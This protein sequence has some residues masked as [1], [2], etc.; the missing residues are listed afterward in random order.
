MQLGLSKIFVTNKN[1]K[2]LGLL[3]KFG[4]ARCF[5]SSQA[6]SHDFLVCVLLILDE[7]SI[8]HNFTP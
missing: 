7:F 8:I 5:C 1:Y 4:H 2:Y 6:I 3:C